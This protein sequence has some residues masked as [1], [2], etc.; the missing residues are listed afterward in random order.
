M[1]FQDLDDIQ[2]REIVPGYRARFVHAEKMTLAY[3]EVEAGAALPE[4]S[5]P[6]EQI[7]NVLEGEFELTVNGESRVL[8]PG[9][10]AVIPGNVPHSGR[11][12]T[13]CRLLDAFQ[14]AREDY[15]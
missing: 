12:V 8:V 7:A 11:A 13:D 10:V 6:H 2:E 9:Q 1:V 15:R 3:W 5:H 14:P 4:H